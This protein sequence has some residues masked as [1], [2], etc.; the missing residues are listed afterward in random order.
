VKYFSWDPEKNEWL[1]EERGIS[2][3]E[4]VFHVEQGDVLDVLEHHNPDRYPGQLLMVVRVDEYVYLV[5]MVE[6]EREIVL[7]TIIPS[8]KATRDYLG[9]N[10][11]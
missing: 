8:R 1:K 5:P 4:I 7:K 3:E 9:S 10:R 6:G 11:K 2:F